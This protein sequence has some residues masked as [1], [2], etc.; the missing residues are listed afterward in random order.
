MVG[1]NRMLPK[2]GEAI[3]LAL[4]RCSL[5]MVAMLELN[6]LDCNATRGVQGLENTERFVIMCYTRCL[7]EG[8]FAW[9]RMGGTLVRKL[10]PSRAKDEATESRKLT[11]HVRRNG[12]RY[13]DP[14]EFFKTPGIQKIV[15]DLKDFKLSEK[16]ED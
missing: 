15:Q 16:A 10:F 3:S 5:S 8:H 2:I 4:R 14:H 1:S 9:I 12:S 11:V 7:H 13:V 6:H